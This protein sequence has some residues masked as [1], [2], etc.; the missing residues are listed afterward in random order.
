LLLAIF[1]Y[2]QSILGSITPF[3]RDEM[4]LTKVEIGW[5]FSVYALGLFSAGR[6]V[7]ML[8]GRYAAGS[9]MMISAWAMVGF[10]AVLAIPMPMAGTLGA[11]L[12]LGLAGGALQV[13]IQ[14]ALARHHGEG[15]GIALT[16]GYI[17]GGLGVLAG[18]L[19]IGLAVKAGLGWRETLVI[20]A[21]LL[22]LLVV[23]S[24]KKNLVEVARRPT[25]AIAPSEHARLPVA[26]I[27]VLGMIL[28]GIATE[29]GI[30]FWGAQ[31]LEVHLSVSPATGVTL[32]SAFFGGTVVGRLFA[33]R[34]LQSFEVR[35]LL[36][37]TIIFG[38]SSVFVLWAEPRFAVA[39]A[40]LII[41]GMCLGNFFPLILSVANEIAPDQP[42]AISAGATQAV[43]F[44]LLIVPALLGRL[45]EAVGLN[46]A[47]GL[48]A[49]FPAAMLA[50]YG[51]STGLREKAKVPA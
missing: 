24:G 11:S 20:P 13:S 45:G 16:E 1:G 15:Q 2:H 3:L 23:L 33:S 41:A 8:S 29:W 36:L 21:L 40:T 25:G 50:L 44:A 31:F 10:V 6:I 28:L 39:T 37:A 5:H 46:N 19:V 4:P 35:M 12:C 38:G 27:L 7:S 43:G 47:V 26:A 49:I 14:E 30:G 17:F 9:L 51:L 34:L 18:P 42:G 32:M 22:G 48:L